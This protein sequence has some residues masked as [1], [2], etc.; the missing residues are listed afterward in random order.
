METINEIRHQ[1]HNLIILD[2][3]GSM[4]S[5]KGSIIAGFN[6]LVQ[7]IK[8][9]EKQYPEQEH[10]ISLI[11]F[12]GY[13]NKLIHFIDPASKLAQIDGS[14]YKPDASTPLF[15]AMG[16]GILK[17]KQALEGNPNCNVLV[18]ILTD[19]EENA[20]GEFSGKDIKALVEELKMNNWTF[21]YIGTE[22][23]VEKMAMS[24]SITNT[25]SFDKDDEG[26]HQMFLKESRSRMI[27][28]DKIKMK[29]STMD[30]FYDEEEKK[31]ED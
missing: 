15:D 12:N 11:T 2:E 8:G 30:G 24:I 5:I 21:T 10:L 16:F 26:I 19:G 18:T 25:M 7:T 20:S 6:E 13:G 3:S 23:D 9:I 29:K 28:S 22:H 17:L 14:R 1:V 4:D 31:Q 27:Y